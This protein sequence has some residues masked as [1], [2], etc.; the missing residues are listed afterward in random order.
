MTPR[1][2][3]AP[4]GR[5]I[6]LSGGAAKEVHRFELATG[7]ERLV[8]AEHPDYVTTLCLAPDGRTL[9]TTC[10]DGAVRLWDVAVGRLLTTLPADQ[11][12]IFA[13]SFSPDGRLLATG[14]DNT[15]VLLWDVSA[16]TRRA[17]PQPPPLTERERD[18]LWDDLAAS[19]PARA[20]RAMA[21]LAAAP[22]EAA[23]LLQSHLP[24]D[25]EADPKRLARLLADLDA[26]EFQAREAASRE[27]ERL[28]QRA[29][30]ALR[31]AL[32][33]KPSPEAGRRL[34]ALLEKLDEPLTAPDNLRLL[35]ALEVLEAAG[36]RTALQP[37]A[38]DGGGGW[39]EREAAESLERLER[40]RDEK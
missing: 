28:G 4:D 11:G 13:A 27:L 33:S 29:E 12:N 24:R 15:T 19:D 39:L 2:A 5:T 26:N 8:F 3:L 23:R 17:P 10:E 6:A 22:E 30:G 32:E 40:R 1:G 34:R 20:G 31:K 35:R 14:G 25:E 7:R 9:A 37:L 18:A 21:R 38:R 16:W 36:A